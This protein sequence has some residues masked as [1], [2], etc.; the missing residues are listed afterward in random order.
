[1]PEIL[2]AHGYHHML[3]ADGLTGL[4]GRQKSTV[5]TVF[6]IE[7]LDEDRH[8]IDLFLFLKP[9]RVGQ[10]KLERQRFDTGGRQPLDLQELLNGVDSKGSMC[11]SLR[12]R[13]YMPAGM[14]TFQKSM[15][16]PR[17]T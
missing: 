4:H 1:M 8:G 15:G 5:L 2:E 10:V 7:P 13:R 9:L 14:L 11:T 12:V 17:T 6:G 3:G 16:F